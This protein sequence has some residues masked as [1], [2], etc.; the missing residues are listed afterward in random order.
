MLIELQVMLLNII[1]AKLP[2]DLVVQLK[3]IGS[4]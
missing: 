1:I 2:Q 4:Q 3:A